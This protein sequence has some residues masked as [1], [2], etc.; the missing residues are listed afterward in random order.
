MFYDEQKTIEACKEEPSLIWGLIK[1]G[2]KGCID[3]LIDKK[4]VDINML[5]DNESNLIMMLLKRGWYDL[6]L[7]HM[8]NK[9]WDVNHQNNDGDTF[10]HILV[11]KNYLEVMDI[12][13][14]LLKNQDFMPNISNKKGETILDKSINNNYISATVK[15]LEDERFNNIDLVSF[16]NLYEKYIKSN[17]YGTYSKVN[18]LEIIIDNLSPKELLP[19][20]GMLIELIK[21]NLKS[22]KADVEQNEM[23]SLDNIIYGVLEESLA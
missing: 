3:K 11:T 12:I 17:K 1:E 4:I 10:A 5:N 18:N 13:K 6:V 19:K 16:K 7:K 8:K 15:I 2:H 23:K 20:L 14:V 22:I 21:E 9:N